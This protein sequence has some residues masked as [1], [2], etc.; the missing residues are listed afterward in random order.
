MKADCFRYFQGCQTSWRP[1]QEFWKDLASVFI[2]LTTKNSSALTYDSGH[3]AFGFPAV[4]TK[5]RIP[6]VH[7][8][9]WCHYA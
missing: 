9:L 2:G 4:T 1:V 8:V 3:V 5:A 6:R 7:H